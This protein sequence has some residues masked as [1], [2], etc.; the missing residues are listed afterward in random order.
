MFHI[1][2][3]GC[4]AQG[5]ESAQANEIALCWDCWDFQ[6]PIRSLANRR[7]ETQSVGVF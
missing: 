2:P 6:T 5:G 1:L 4:A 7:D 3:H